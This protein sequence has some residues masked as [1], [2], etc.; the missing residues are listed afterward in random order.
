MKIKNILF[1]NELY[2][3]KGKKLPM[4]EFRRCFE[5]SYQLTIYLKKIDKIQEDLMLQV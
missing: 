1:Y 4:F 3:K 2:D 5:K